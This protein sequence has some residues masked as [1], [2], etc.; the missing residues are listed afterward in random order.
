MTAHFHSYWIGQENLEHRKTLWLLNNVIGRFQEIVLFPGSR[1][2]ESGTK[3]GRDS[4]HSLYRQKI[5]HECQVFETSLTDIR[6]CQ[7]ERG[8][9][10]GGSS[11]I[12]VSQAIS[13]VAPQLAS[14]R[15]GNKE[16]S[17]KMT[18]LLGKTSQIG[19][20]LGTWLRGMAAFDW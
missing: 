5:T 6:Q 1:V 12:L 14:N 3:Q 10:Q 9:C 16:G 2:S 13:Q 15:V 11:I 20:R 8:K 7:T 19:E 4:L 18:T 17:M